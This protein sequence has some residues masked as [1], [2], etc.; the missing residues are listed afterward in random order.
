MYSADA[1]RSEREIAPER[2]MTVGARDA[3]RAKSEG[4]RPA[5]EN[6]VVLRAGSKSLPTAVC[7]CGDV[8]RPSSGEAAAM[9][10]SS[11]V[12]A[13]LRLGRNSPGPAL[14]PTTVP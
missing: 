9:R 7:A 5:N 11:W 4:V 13:V 2:G 6:G 3:R 12:L 10:S 14:A 1:V 8:T